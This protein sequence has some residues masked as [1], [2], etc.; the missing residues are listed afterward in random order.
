MAPARLHTQAP[1]ART[2]IHPGPFN[3][4][5][6]QSQHATHGRHIRLALA[7][8][9]SLY[10]GLVKPLAALGITSASMT[11]LGGY[12]ERLDYCV[13]PPDPSKRALIAYSTPIPLGRTY[14][15]FGNAT[16][17]FDLQ[18]K[19]LVHCHAAMRTDT[20]A[21]QGGHVI[22]EE[23]IIG[24]W[25]IPVLVTSLEGFELRQIYD[26]EINI[27]VLKPLREQMI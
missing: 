24:P 17:G 18:G 21:V 6:I 3:P 9:Q 23:T 16:L 19:P 2:M 13:A 14:I 1:R 7:P 26:P 10:D 25:P 5:R 4:V 15:I 22:T 8:G 11:I 12:A 27:S 20:G